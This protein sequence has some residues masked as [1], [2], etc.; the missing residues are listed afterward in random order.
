M[1]KRMADR[2]MRDKYGPCFKQMDVRYNGPLGCLLPYLCPCSLQLSLL[3]LSLFVY[4]IMVHC[5]ALFEPR[6]YIW[7]RKFNL[8]RK[9]RR[10]GFPLDDS[11]T[12]PKTFLKL[13]KRFQ[14]HVRECAALIHAMQLR[15][16]SSCFRHFS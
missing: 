15:L 12:R 3:Y 6:R 8:G 4:C 2:A 13:S 7:K 1:R 5:T 10:G 16:A 14:L 9:Q 11:L